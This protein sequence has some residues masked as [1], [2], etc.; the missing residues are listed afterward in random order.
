MGVPR[1]DSP[2]FIDPRVGD[3]GERP[4]I[5]R[6]LIGRLKACCFTSLRFRRDPVDASCVWEDASF[7]PLALC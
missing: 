2:G 1:R 4:S 6:S 3:R 7:K 5:A